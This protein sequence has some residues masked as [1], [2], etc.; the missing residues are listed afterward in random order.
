MSKLYKD[1]KD[2]FSGIY[3]LAHF[4]LNLSQVF[5]THVPLLC[6]QGRRCVPC[7]NEH[8]RILLSEL[9][10]GCHTQTQDTAETLQSFKRWHKW[11]NIQKQ[12]DSR[13]QGS[14]NEWPHFINKETDTQSW[15][16][17]RPAQRGAKG[18][19]Q[20]EAAFPLIRWAA[21]VKPQD[22]LTWCWSGSR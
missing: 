2:C 4:W 18:Q 5:P 14:S 20:G 21:P 22:P 7:L 13:K 3:D 6:G 1:T 16:Q 12:H 9:V 11:W 17:A 10:E 8:L 19:S 15:S